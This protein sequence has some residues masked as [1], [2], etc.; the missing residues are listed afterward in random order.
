LATANRQIKLMGRGG[1]LIASEKEYAAYPKLAMPVT[2][3]SVHGNAY[4]AV[5]HVLNNKT[6]L[7][8]TAPA[9]QSIHRSFREM[10]SVGFI[11]FALQKT[12]HGVQGV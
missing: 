3:S 8:T 4:R 6:K 7:P 10:E 12:L 5:N 1:F 2:N 11:H 9:I